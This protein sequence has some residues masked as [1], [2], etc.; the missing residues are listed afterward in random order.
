MKKQSETEKSGS[1]STDAAAHNSADALG[2]ILSFGLKDEK[3]DI[4]RFGYGTGKW[5]YLC[6]AL[7]DIQ[8]DIKRNNYNVFVKK[9]KLSSD[10]S[11]EIKEEIRSS[12]NMSLAMV[13]QAYE[14]TENKTLVPIVYNIIYDGTS[15]PM[16]DI[17]KVKDKNE[18]SL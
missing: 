8:K 9:Y 11:E 17:L 18:R 5:V 1:D 12:L 3:D 7:D 6:D 13:C 16:N 10:L 14:G 2:K 4:Y 15:N